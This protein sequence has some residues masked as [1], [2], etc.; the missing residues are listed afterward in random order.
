MNIVKAFDIET[1]NARFDLTISAK[2][3]GKGFVGEY[4]GT[5]PK[6]AQVVRP[7]DPTPMMRD[8]GSGKLEHQDLAELIAACRAEIE[9]LDGNIQRTIERKI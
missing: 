8:I 6:F 2:S 5:A 9:K 1:A 4:F 3:D 7:G